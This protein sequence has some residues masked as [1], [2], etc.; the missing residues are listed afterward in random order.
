[1]TSTLLVNYHSSKGSA[2]QLTSR[3]FCQKEFLII[4][5]QV[6]QHNLQ[7]DSLIQR[8]S[9]TWLQKEEK[10]WDHSLLRFNDPP[11]TSDS[12]NM[13]ES[14]LVSKEQVFEL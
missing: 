4:I 7:G 14:S 11:S 2:Q 6:N 10:I 1:M 13:I 12:T 5:H 9:R 8:N 3:Q